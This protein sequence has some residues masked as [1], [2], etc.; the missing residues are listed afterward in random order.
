[1]DCFPSVRHPLP[2]SEHLMPSEQSY[3]YLVNP[4]AAALWF[5]ARHKIRERQDFAQSRK[6]PVIIGGADDALVLK[7]IAGLVE[8]PE[9]EWAQ[10]ID[11]AAKYAKFWAESAAAI[12]DDLVA[13]ADAAAA[14]EDAAAVEDAAEAKAVAAAAAVED[15]A[16]AKAAAADAATAAADN[17]PE[18]VLICT[19]S[20]EAEYRLS[21][22]WDKSN[23]L[24]IQFKGKARYANKFNPDAKI[25]FI[26][27]LMDTTTPGLRPCDAFDLIGGVGTGG[28]CAIILGRLGLTVDD[29]SKYLPAAAILPSI[30]EAANLVPILDP[31]NDVGST[32]NENKPYIFVVA[33]LNNRQDEVLLRSYYAPCEDSEVSRQTKVPQA[34][35]ATLA[36]VYQDSAEYEDLATYLEF[37]QDLHPNMRDWK[38]SPSQALTTGED[39]VDATTNDPI[40]H[41]YRE[42]REFWPDEE[43][44]IASFM[45]EPKSKS[46]GSTAGRDEVR[47]FRDLHIS[48]HKGD[49]GQPLLL[50]AVNRDE[51][52][53]PSFAEKAKAFWAD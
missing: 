23:R 53:S 42:A 15:A 12:A 40:Y 25:D 22:W 2:D 24:L 9:V 5:A 8:I 16:G 38:F 13:E 28:V 27:G 3:S 17:R 43:I 32:C 14:A 46:P 47:G 21:E 52:A 30:P 4:K 36:A 37:A 51:I 44:R 33:N 41:V 10:T 35:L 26:K 45:P 20:K 39:Q 7:Q 19:I 49:I 18:F 34:S 50:R 48:N 31:K 29:C 11:E 1:M 6:V